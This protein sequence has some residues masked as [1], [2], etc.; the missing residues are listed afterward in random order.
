[1]AIAATLA[2]N[3]AHG[4]DQGLTGAGVAAWPAVAQVG[5]YELLMMV[6]L[7][8]Q[9]PPTVPRPAERD[10]DSLQEQAAELFAGQLAEA[11]IP[12]ERDPCSAP[13]RP[14]P[15]LAT[16]GLPRDR[17]CEAAS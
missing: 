1:V 12:S 15:G 8:S 14:A 7:S 3:V 4:L 10:A 2:A 17:R 5:S 16:A 13:R 9:V 11:R 6:I